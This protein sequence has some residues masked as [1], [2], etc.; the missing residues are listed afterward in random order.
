MSNKKKM[1][2]KTELNK[3]KFTE[4]AFLYISFN[5]HNI[6]R[7]KKIYSTQLI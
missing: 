7:L 2:K 4:I 3:D 5:N 1:N 6:D